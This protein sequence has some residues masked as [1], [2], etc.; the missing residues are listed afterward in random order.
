M[1][2]VTTNLWTWSYEAP[3]GLGVTLPARSVMIEL[4]NGRLVII[5]PGPFDDATL[6]WIKR[7]DPAPYLV[8]PN[9]FHHFYLRLAMQQLP[10]SLVFGPSGLVKKQPDLSGELRE[11]GELADQL[12]E[13]LLM[14]PLHGNHVLSETAFFHQ[15]SRSMIV[16]DSLFHLQEPMPLRRRLALTLVGTYNQLAESRIVRWSCSDRERFRRDFCALLDLEPERIIPAHGT[17]VKDLP[18]VRRLFEG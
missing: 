16:T 5:S 3:L 11:L 18:A 7:H 4:A 1:E 8:A 6:T 2:A 9:M 15:P 10:G 12:D 13:T 17:I 14:R